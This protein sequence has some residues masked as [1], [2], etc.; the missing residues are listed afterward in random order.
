[1]DLGFLIDGSGSIEQA[2]RGNFKKELNFVKQIV[3]GFKVCKKSTHV[4]VIIFSSNAK[5]CMKVN[6]FV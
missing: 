4:G 6:D 2:G 1:M 3:N 5:V